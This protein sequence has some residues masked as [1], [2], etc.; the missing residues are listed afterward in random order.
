MATATHTAISHHAVDTNHLHQKSAAGKDAHCHGADPSENNMVFPMLLIPW[1]D[2]AD[3]AAKWKL[4]CDFE[5][6]T[7]AL[8]PTPNFELISRS[9]V[10]GSMNSRIRS[11]RKEMM[12]LD[13]SDWTKTEDIAKQCSRSRDTTR[14]RLYGLEKLGLVEC[15]R[16]KRK[17]GGGCVLHWRWTNV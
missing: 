1:I 4:V 10:G 2:E 5:G 3:L 14:K 6:H 7:P 8:P 15:R 11:V 12:Q 17:D 9:R 16:M 13:L